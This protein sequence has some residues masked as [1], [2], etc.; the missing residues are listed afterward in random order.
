MVHSTRKPQNKPTNGWI[1]ADFVNINLEDRQRAE[2]KALDWSIADFD[3]AC[4]VLMNLGYKLSVR[5]DERNDSF[6]AWII[7]PDGSA[8]KGQILAG[9]G[10]T[11]FKAIKQVMYI[12]FK[13][14]DT[15]WGENQGQKAIEI[16]D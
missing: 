1:R 9:R 5:Y 13:I 3:T 7:A 11:A 6:A 8:N 10:S 15:D 16:D 2:L 4:S 14:L 12:H